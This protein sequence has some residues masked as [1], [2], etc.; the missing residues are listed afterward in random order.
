MKYP[1]IS[2]FNGGNIT[3]FKDNNKIWLKGKT[4]IICNGE[5]FYE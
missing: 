3:I 5:Y 4:K 1:I 2:I